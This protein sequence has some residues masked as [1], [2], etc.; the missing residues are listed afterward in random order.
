MERSADERLGPHGAPRDD[1][2]VVFPLV[3]GHR[4]TSATA[5]A[6]FA[7]AAEVADPSLAEAIRAEPRWHKGYPT[8]VRRLLE[9]G[10]DRAETPVA[11]ARAG[12]DAAH[13]RFEL[14]TDDGAVPTARALAETS[15]EPLATATI[16]GRG[17]APGGVA[18][19]YGGEMLRGDALHRQLDR[20]VGAGVVEPSLAEAVRAVMA[21]PDWLDL[22]DQRVVCLG[23]GAEL[24]PLAHLCGWART[25]CR[26]TWE[27]PVCGEGFS[28]RSAPAG[29]GRRC[30]CAPRP[31][32]TTTR[33]SPR[34]PAPT[35]PSTCRRSRP[36]CARSTAR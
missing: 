9:A 1:C 33:P 15:G 5:R 29:D 36:G 28:P 35:S 24:G 16:E 11:A 20:W 31:T 12:L 34:P 18:T 3:D 30:R 17:E 25:C 10:L 2:G 7:A 6:V 8:H 13:A 23:A 26:S 21:N 19:P 22:S 32:P 14:A 27:T 4:S